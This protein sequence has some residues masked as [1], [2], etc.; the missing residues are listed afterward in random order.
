MIPDQTKPIS[1]WKKFGDKRESDGMFFFYYTKTKRKDGTVSIGEKWGTAE[2][3]DAYRKRNREYYYRDGIKEKS[4]KR[5][6]EY[7]ANN[8]EH[9]KKLRSLNKKKHKEQ[10]KESSKRYRSDPANKAKIRE[11]SLN[12]QRKNPE[13]IKLYASRYRNQPWAKK[14]IAQYVR[15]RRRTNP[16]E[17]LAATIRK[18]VSEALKVKSIKKLHSTSELLGCSFAFLKKHI[19]SQFKD[20]M[21]WEN[22]SSFHIDHIR[23]LASFD[24]TDPEQ[25]KAACHWTN[26]QP[27][28]P[29]ENLKKSKKFEQPDMSCV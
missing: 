7:Y 26:L 24:L 23:P 8:K 18:R 11:T 21:S 9:V 16:Q 15:E 25:L 3:I 13:K 1:C 29:K 19:E 10:I 22:R 27:L 12:W 14:R 4:Q 20:G 28:Y 5:F 6:K 2:E 17:N